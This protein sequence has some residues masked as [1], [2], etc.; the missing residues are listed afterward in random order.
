MPCLKQQREWVKVKLA[1]DGHDPG[2]HSMFVAI[3]G[4]L[5][6]LQR[7]VDAEVEVRR[8][9]LR[10]AESAAGGPAGSQPAPAIVQRDE[11]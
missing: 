1:F 6:N 5:E 11:S 3:L 8:A 9:N 7:R 10:G 2:D 4:S